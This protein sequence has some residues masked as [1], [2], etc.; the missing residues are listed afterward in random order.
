ML[1]TDGA[2]ILVVDDDQVNRHLLAS[3]LSGEGYQ[4]ESVERGEA[5]LKSVKLQA[6][7]IILLDVMMPGIDGFE[8]ARKLKE[9]PE[10]ESIPIIMV[11]SLS[12][13][14]SRERGLLEGVEEFINKPLIPNELVIRV[15]NLL[16]LKLA[17]DILKNHNVVLEEEVQRRSNELLKSFEEGLYMLMRAAEYRDDET[18][19]HIRR[20]SYYTKALA[21][22]LGMESQYCETIFLASPMHDIG[23]IGIPDQILLKPGPF[24]P[25]EWNLMKRHTTIGAEILAGGSSPYMQMGH[26]IALSHHERWDGSGYPHNLAGEDIPLSARIMSICDIY[27]ALRSKRPYKSAFNHAKAIRII[28]DGDE[29]I[30]CSHFDPAV[31]EA[32][33]SKSADFGEIYDSI[34]S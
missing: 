12:D 22:S 30:K 23:K 28:R 20:I 18:G 2:N 21:G 8:V 3:I 17:N 5:A 9:S 24:D 31:L 7:D 33:L 16:R 32:F 29:R 10:S 1:N 27:D 11:T 14:E 19:A 6:P 25:H 34:S 4:V 26:E 15:R 13:Q